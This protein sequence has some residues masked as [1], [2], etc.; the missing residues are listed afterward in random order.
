MKSL[1]QQ[2]EAAREKRR[3]ADADAEAEQ[4]QQE[5]EQQEMDE[6]RQRQLQRERLAQ[7]ELAAAATHGAG[8]SGAGARKRKGPPT[9]D[10]SDL[11]RTRAAP[12][13]PR[14]G[15]AA[16]ASGDSAIIPMPRVALDL[17]SQLSNSAHQ[18]AMEALAH[19]AQVGHLLCLLASLHMPSAVSW[20]LCLQMCMCLSVR[21][22]VLTI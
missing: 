16:S 19:N 17:I 9:G 15:A 1:Q 6:L 12:F 7:D 21:V 13:G 8:A 14:E 3:Q 11:G 22:C 10:S 4:Q 20:W 2:L 5:Q 18:Q